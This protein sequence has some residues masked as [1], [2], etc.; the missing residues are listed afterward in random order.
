M[1]ERI[2]QIEEI[3]CNA[4]DKAH[5]EH[6]ESA[7]SP[8]VLRKSGVKGVLAVRS[9]LPRACVLSAMARYNMNDTNHS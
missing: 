4:R 1:Q 3:S 2:R 9:R 7:Y 5:S 8:I 6:I